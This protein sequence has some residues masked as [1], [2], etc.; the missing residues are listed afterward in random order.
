MGVGRCLAGGP[1]LSCPTAD[2]ACVCIGTEYGAG[3]KEGAAFAAWEAAG[4]AAGVAEA[5]VATAEAP[6]VACA[7]ANTGQG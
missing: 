2:S 3:V 4:G 6:I 7:G 5:G 1:L